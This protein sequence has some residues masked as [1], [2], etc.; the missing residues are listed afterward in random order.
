MI[1]PLGARVVIERSKVGERI[2]SGGV[3]LPEAVHWADTYKGEI[4]AIGEEVEHLEVDSIQIAKF[5]DGSNNQGI[6]FRV[7]GYFLAQPF[8]D[9]FHAPQ[10]HLFYDVKHTR[11]RH[12]RKPSRLL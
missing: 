10:A 1:R 2:T 11:T 6:Y 12:D 9:A 7:L 4:L 8:I 3:V 5:S